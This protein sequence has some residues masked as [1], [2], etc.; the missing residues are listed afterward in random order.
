MVVQ[1]LNENGM[2]SP[3]GHQVTGNQSSKVPQGSAASLFPAYA[4]ASGPRAAGWL[5]NAS[6]PAMPAQPKAASGTEEQEAR[7]KLCKLMLERCILV[8]DTVSGQNHCN[9]SEHV[10]L[11]GLRL[12][13]AAEQLLP[14]S[15]SDSESEGGTDHKSDEVPAPARQTAQV[16]DTGGSSEESSHRKRKRRREHS[17]QRKHKKNR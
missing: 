3:D 12:K 8:H 16:A 7:S 2:S 6:F 1:P 17:K 4:G 9:I 5:Q 10:F 13:Q 15:G 11:S 14:S